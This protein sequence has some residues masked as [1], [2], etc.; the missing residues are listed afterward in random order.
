MYFTTTIMKKI[1]TVAIVATALMG[2]NQKNDYGAIFHNP[3]LYSNTAHELNGV[4]MGNNFNPVVAS[5]NYTYA[6]IAGY[7]VI[8]AGMPDQYQSLAG[9]IKGLTAILNRRLETKLIFPMLHC[10]LIVKW[11]RR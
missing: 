4:V 8:A 2:C 11:V 6:A 9:Q 7:E 10:S 3:D 5:R 1:L